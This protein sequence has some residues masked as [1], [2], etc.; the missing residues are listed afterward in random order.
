MNNDTKK[1]IISLFV[2][3][4]LAG[5]AVLYLS[6]PLLTG[7]TVVLATRPVDPF[8]PLRG[9]YITIAYEIGQIPADNSINIGD[10]VYVAISPDNDGI[11]RFNSSLKNL[12]D[13]EFFI[14]GTVTQIYGNR[15]TVEYGIEQFYFE[16]N[17]KFTTQNM[18]VEV[19]IDKFGNARIR[20]LLQDGKPMVYNYTQTILG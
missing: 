15:A 16:R 13:A 7:K 1:L 20:K 4:V 2:F 6:Y 10:T 18:T 19:K 5:A 14:K 12:P 3:I 9:Q 8:D 11:F 17:A